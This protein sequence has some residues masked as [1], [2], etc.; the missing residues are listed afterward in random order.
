MPAK[1]IKELRQA[2]KLNEALII[3]KAELNAAT[4][5]IWAKRNISWVYY[6]FLKKNESVENYDLFVSFLKD[7]VNLQLPEDEKMFFE[8]LCW[9]IGKM[10]FALHKANPMDIQKIDGLFELIKNFHF[11]KPAPSF[12]Y[13]Y[14][15]FHKAFKESNSYLKFADWWDFQ[16]FM[17]EDFH[18]DK[19]PNG[20]E[21]MAIAEQAYIT[22]SKQLLPKTSGFGE[23]IFDKEKALAFIPILSGIEEKYPEFQFPA[24]FHAKLLVAVGEKENMLETLLPFAKKKK[25]EFWVWELLAAAFPNDP[26]KV[27]TCFCK[28]LSCKAP[29]EMLIGLRQKMAEMLIHRKLYNEAKTEIDLLINVRNTHGFRV[30]SQIGIWQSQDWYKNA[31]ANKSNI[32]F[33]RPFSSDAELILFSDIPEESV[34]V[35][36]INSDKK[37]LNFIASE[38]K[39]GFFKYDRF[40]KEVKIGNVLKVR[41]QGGSNE[42][43]HQLYTAVKSTDD[44]FKKQ[45]FRQVEGEVKIL[46]GKSFGF[47]DN[48]YIHPTIVSRLKLT[49]GTQISGFA[50]KTYNRE[51]RQWS[52]K[53]FL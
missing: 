34:I 18:K 38:S 23:I 42:G 48:V 2:G 19:L 24:Y 45:F 51:K 9:Q 29:E 3:A 12:S 32:D 31:T 17:P 6:E 11:T 16:N 52:W 41:F 26:D 15:A 33:Y 43:M 1:E 25:S 28:A 35:E 44:D 5:N 14:K 40:F 7:I 36:F 27:F 13:L 30:P 21:V 4:D 37:I 10:V 39:F 50:M 49:D 20:K 22:Y 47:L 46:P 8:N 53:F